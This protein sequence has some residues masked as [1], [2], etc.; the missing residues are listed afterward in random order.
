MPDRPNESIQLASQSLET[1][2]ANHARGDVRATLNRF[3]YACFHAAQGV[4]YDRGFE[5]KTHKGVRMLFGREVV[6]P[7]DATDRG[8]ELLS[9]LQ[10]LREHADCDLTSVSGDINR[11]DR[12]IDGFIDAMADLIDDGSEEDA[13][14]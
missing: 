8:A 10:D 9:D 1:A 13:D 3:Y 2:R 12:R 14:A 11:L 5:P 7:I 6:Q 4:V